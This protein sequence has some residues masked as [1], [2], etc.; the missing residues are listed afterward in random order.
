MLKSVLSRKAVL[1]D[2]AGLIS[3]RVLSSSNGIA[4]SRDILT[5]A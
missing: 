2:M 3:M 5:L 4:G 1:G